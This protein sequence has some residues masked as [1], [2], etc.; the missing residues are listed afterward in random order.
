[1]EVSGSVEDLQADNHGVLPVEHDEGSDSLG[2]ING[3]A[4]AAGRQLVVGQVDAGSIG[5]GI[6]GDTH[7]RIMADPSQARQAASRLCGLWWGQRRRSGC[8]TG[9]DDRAWLGTGDAGAAACAGGLALKRPCFLLTGRAGA[10]RARSADLVIRDKGHRCSGRGRV[11]VRTVAPP[12]RVPGAAR[13][14]ACGVA[15]RWWRREGCGPDPGVRRGGRRAC[16]VRCV[17]RRRTPFPAPAGASRDSLAELGSRPARRCRDL[18]PVGALA[19]RLT[20]GVRATVPD[21]IAVVSAC[22]ALARLSM[23]LQRRFGYTELIPA[24]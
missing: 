21:R 24:G 19:T 15:G 5:F 23:N 2:R 8:W 1:M 22:R 16:G 14:A 11:Q 18:G 6:V 10:R 7:L 9:R 3:D 12:R 4:V 13:Q 20:S 17:R